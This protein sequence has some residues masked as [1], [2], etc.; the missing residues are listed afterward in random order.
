MFDIKFFMKPGRNLV[1][2]EEPQSH[3]SPSTEGEH[4]ARRWAQRAVAAWLTP[5]LPGTSPVCAGTFDP[6][7]PS[8]YSVTQQL[9]DTSGFFR[10][11]T[12][13]RAR[14]NWKWEKH[15]DTDALLLGVLSARQVLFP[16]D[17]IEAISCCY[18]PRA[19]VEATGWQKAWQIYATY[20]ILM[21][22]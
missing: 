21:R 6:R 22:N 14:G 1:A 16:W 7:C 10:R 15:K 13:V 19:V 5:A 3:G 2:G 8:S 12:R 11:S 4:V 18:Q 9:K 20:F 17:Q